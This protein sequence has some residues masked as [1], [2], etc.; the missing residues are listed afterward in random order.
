MAATADLL[1]EPVD[2]ES[3]V[4]SMGYRD[5]LAKYDE[6]RGSMRLLVTSTGVQTINI[7]PLETYLRGVV[8]AEMPA[9]WAL[10]AVKAQAV[11]ARTYAWDRMNPSRV[12]D[13]LPTSANQVYGGYQLEHWHSDLAVSQ[14]TNMIMTFNGKAIGAVYHTCAGGYTEDGQYVF[15]TSAGNPGTNTKYLKGKADVDE[16]GVAYDL[17]CPNFSWQTGQFTM[18][19]LSA[20]YATDPNTNVGDIFNITYKRGVSGRAYQ[21]TIEGSLGTATISGNKFK[22]VYNRQKLSGPDIKS[23]MYILTPVAQLN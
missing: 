6:Y 19:Q 17:S 14:T 5:S 13:I 8:P 3:G 9:S 23:N 16:N 11:A 21:V 4:L 1:I 7:L 15:A 2:P 22:T 10:E 12:W 18:S 20:I